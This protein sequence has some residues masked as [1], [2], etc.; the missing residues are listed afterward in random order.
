MVI[1][2]SILCYFPGVKSTKMPYSCLST[3]I[4]LEIVLTSIDVC[5]TRRVWAHSSIKNALTLMYI[6]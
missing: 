5:K 2:E 1:L 6:F 4:L 3:T